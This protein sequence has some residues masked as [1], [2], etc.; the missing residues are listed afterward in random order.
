M[1]KKSTKISTRHVH[2]A[3][4][5][6]IDELI[7]MG[8]MGWPKSSILYRVMT[9]GHVNRVGRPGHKILA[10]EMHDHSRWVQPAFNA[11]SVGDK[12]IVITKHRPKPTGYDTWT[13]K[14]M[15]HY[16]NEHSEGAFKAKYNKILKKMLKRLA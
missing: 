14:D 5:R 4:A 10:P 7:R 11:L 1:S 3:L 6:L 8:D 12:I 15:A 2:L 16:L 9:E 13:D